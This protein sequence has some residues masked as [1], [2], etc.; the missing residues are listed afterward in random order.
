MRTQGIHPVLALF[1]WMF[2]TGCPALPQE[3]PAAIASKEKLAMTEQY[4]NSLRMHDITLPKRA[5][6]IPADFLERVAKSWKEFDAESRDIA[7]ST[8]SQM[9]VRAAGQ[10]L[11]SVA[12]LEGEE[13]ATAAASALI[14][15][16][17]AP[18]GNTILAATQRSRDAITRSRLYL[19]A[20]THGAAIAVFEPIA[21]KETNPEARQAAVE[22]M[23]RLA[24]LP[25]LHALYDRTA[26][27]TASEVVRIHEA[28][29]YVR[30]KRLA[31]A[32]ISWLIKTDP[33]MRMGSD[34]SPAMIRQ[35]DYALW[36]AHVLGVAVSL[37]ANHID[38]F[39][40]APL[41]AAKPVLQ[42]L[43]DLPRM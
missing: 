29:V 2:L 26:K 28:L 20:G 31:K 22:G 7:V 11:L 42:A 38:N 30:D 12:G 18:D 23:A 15:H 5:A 36:T 27:A 39:T 17:D 24:H 32:L 3:K 8:A 9:R 40:P 35:C 14:N 16:P 6:D 10:F 4:L 19:A 34:R 37:P 43:P 1:G 33:V 41:A 13:S 21:A 25:S